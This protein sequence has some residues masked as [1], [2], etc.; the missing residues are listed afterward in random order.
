MLLLFYTNFILL[1][2]INE[3]LNLGVLKGNKVPQKKRVF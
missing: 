3:K 1:L 2:G